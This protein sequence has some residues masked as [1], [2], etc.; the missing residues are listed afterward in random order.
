MRLCSSRELTAALERLGCY[1]G[2]AG[3]SSHRSYHR[4]MPDGR[5]LT[6]PVVLGRREVARGTLRNIL[7]WLEIS[8]AEFEAAL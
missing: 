5:R 1:P 2:R 7:R 6:A 4:D 3:R 8:E